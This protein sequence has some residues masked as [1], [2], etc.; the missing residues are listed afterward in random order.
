MVL[1]LEELGNAA[2]AS[3]QYATA[4]DYFTRAIAQSSTSHVAFGRSPH[5]GLARA[6]AALDNLDQA[7]AH[8]VEALA[9]SETVQEPFHMAEVHLHLG[10]L[11][12]ARQ[13]AE[14]SAEHFDSVVKIAKSIGHTRL[15]LDALIRKA[16]VSFELEGAAETY[17]ILTKASEMA[18]AIGDRDAELQ[19]RTHIIYFQLMEHGFKVK[20][21]TFSSLLSMGRKM[22]LSRTPALCWLFRADVSTARQNWAEARE[23]LKQAYSAAS[24]L[25]DYAM[26]ILIA[27]RD[28]LLQQKLN[29]LGDPHIGAGWALGGLVPPEIGPRREALSGE[30]SLER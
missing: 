7:E 19:V 30:Y 24:Q 8:L 16:Y 21:D 22:Y 18:Q 9:T 20:G 23:E 1:C 29:Q 15:W 11:Y 10:D 27:R 14:A 4:R 12:L 26:F 5:L 13:D 6:L 25:G 17:D 28:Y 3:S 2:Y